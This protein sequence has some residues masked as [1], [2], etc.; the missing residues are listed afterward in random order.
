[1]PEVETDRH[2]RMDFLYK[3]ILEESANQF[4]IF[5][6][7]FHELFIETVHRKYVLSEE[8]HIARFD[9]FK[10][11]VLHSGEEGEPQDVVDVRDPEGKGHPDQ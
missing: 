10:L 2:E 7:P 6:S 8:T 1:M 5:I 11:S 4:G 9:A 3:S